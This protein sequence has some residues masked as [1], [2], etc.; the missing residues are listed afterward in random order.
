MNTVRSN[1]ISLKYPRFFLLLFTVAVLSVPRTEDLVTKPTDS[2][3]KSKVDCGDV[4]TG[5]FEG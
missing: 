3:D 1:N 2:T 5:K 4:K